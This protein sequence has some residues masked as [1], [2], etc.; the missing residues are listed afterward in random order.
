[1]Q[2]LD[3]WVL[4]AV[5][6]M[7]SPLLNRIATDLTSLGSTTLIV[8]QAG[9]AAVFLILTAKSR[10]SAI[11]VGVAAGGAELWVQIIKRLL[12]RARPQIVPPLVSASGFSTPSGHAASSTALYVTLALIIG[13]RLD[14]PARRAVNIIAAVLVLSIGISRVYLGVHYLSDAVLGFVLGWL[15]SLAAAKLLR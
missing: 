8:V 5:A 7:R 2:P 11:Q 6:G 1:M 3:E 14:P 15:W 4:Q 9:I 10:R 12:R 13:P